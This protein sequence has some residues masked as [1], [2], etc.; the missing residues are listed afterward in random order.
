MQSLETPKHGEQD[1]QGE[2]PPSMSMGGH[3]HEEVDNSAP[4][5]AFPVPPHAQDVWTHLPPHH[6]SSE[7]APFSLQPTDM[8]GPFSALGAFTSPPPLI[9]GGSVS[10]P[11]ATGT[12]AAGSGHDLGPLQCP[13]YAAPLSGHTDMEGPFSAPADLT[14]PPPFLPG[15]GG[16]APLATGGI[17][18]APRDRATQIFFDIFCVETASE[19]GD[20]DPPVQ[21]AG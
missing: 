4:S 7:S 2:A 21:L 12:S 6:A 1:V 15:G 9:P 14:S 18:S 8:E 3:Y 20:A 11:L 10:A 13:P 16:A 19:I 5:P 17:F